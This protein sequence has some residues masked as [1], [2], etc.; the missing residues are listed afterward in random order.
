MRDLLIILF[1]AIMLSACTQ[2]DDSFAPPFD[3]AENKPGGDTTVSIKP[4]ASFEHPAANLPQS[5]RPDF[6]AGKA[7]ANQP[8]VKA[9]T[10]TT[11]RDG[12]GPLYNSRTCLMCHIKGG[13]GF[14]PE[15]GEIP[16]LSSLVRLSI[17]ATNSP[18]HQAML[19]HH[20]VIPHPIYGDQVQGQSTS[21]AHQL[22]HSQKDNDQLKHDIAPEAYVFID[23]QFSEFVYPDGH[24]VRLRKPQLRFENLGYGELGEDTL[25]S[26]RLAPPIHGMGLIELIPQAEITALADENDRNQDGISGRVNHIWDNETEQIVAGRFGWKANKPSVKVQ[27]AAAFNGDVGIST[28]LFPGQPCSSQQTACLKAPTGNDVQNVELADDLLDLVVNFNRNLAPVER[29]NTNHPDV[30]K[31]RN[32]FYQAGCQQCHNPGFTTQSSEQNPHLG[33]QKIWPYSDFLIHDMGPDLAD[34]RPDFTASGSEWRTAPLW[35]IGIQEQVN[36]S[37]AL[38]HDGRAQTIE[39]AIL[40]HGGEAAAVKATFISF[41]QAKRDALIQFVESL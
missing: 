14:V 2:K 5:L 34:N 30:I 33:N 12:L 7:L 36:G 6:H 16:M 19:Q 40:W 23:W 28:T 35:G 9:P 26:L 38:L 41:E 8:W 4:F 18:E 25:T 11:M 3:P 37:K 32:Y 21:L 31:G 10:V 15:N 29:R 39:E 20:G 22:R 24:K 17:P 1:S 13:K 27:T